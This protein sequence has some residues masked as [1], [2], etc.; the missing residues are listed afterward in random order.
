MGNPAEPLR[1]TEAM[2]RRVRTFLIWLLALALPAQGVMAATMVFCGPNHHDRAA[3]VAAAAHED[4]AAHSH[5]ASSDKQAEVPT[6]NEA[7][8][9]DKAAQ[10]GMQ[11]CSVCASC[12]SAAAIPEAVPKLPVL[13]PGAADFAAPASAVEPFAA[14]GPER[15]PRHLLA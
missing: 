11:K 10:A 7:A 12:C 14:D 8:A 3:S 6:S 15:P 5:H 4:G 13:E 1:Y 2:V 9:P